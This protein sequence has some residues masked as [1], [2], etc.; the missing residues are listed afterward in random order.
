MAMHIGK[1]RHRFQRH[2]QKSIVECKEESSEARENILHQPGAAQTRVGAHRRC[3]I[4]I[5]GLWPLIDRYTQSKYNLP[6]NTDMLRRAE[7]PR[8][9]HANRML[10]RAIKQRVAIPDGGFY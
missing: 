3:L 9:T 7:C 5:R 6:Q 2:R 4:R 10:R 8:K 1:S